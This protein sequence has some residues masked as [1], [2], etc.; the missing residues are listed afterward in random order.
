MLAKGN[1]S[2]AQLSDPAEFNPHLPVYVCCR[3]VVV[4]I[5]SGAVRRSSSENSAASRY[6]FFCEFDL[7]FFVLLLIY[8]YCNSGSG[9][10]T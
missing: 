4:G 3:Q 6:H 5:V 2:T 10:D 9:S 1:L 7:S 8:Y